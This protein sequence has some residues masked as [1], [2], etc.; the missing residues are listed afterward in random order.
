MAHCYLTGHK[1]NLCPTLIQTCTNLIQLNT[2]RTFAERGGGRG[3]ARDTEEKGKMSLRRGIPIAKS[4][5]VSRLRVPTN[6]GC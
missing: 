3:G 5:Q 1:L 6:S 2:I 4:S